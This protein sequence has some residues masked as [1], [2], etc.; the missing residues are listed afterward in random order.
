MALRQIALSIYEGP[1]S[2][3]DKDAN[4]KQEVAQYSHV[5]PMPTLDTM[6]KNLNIPA[7]ALVR[8]ILVRWATSGSAGLLDIGPTVVR[9]MGDVVGQAESVGTDEAFLD[10]YHRLAQIISWLQVPLDTRG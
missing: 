8:Y 3:D 6:S 5:D 9:Q 1:W 10:A 4:F 7:G 2:P